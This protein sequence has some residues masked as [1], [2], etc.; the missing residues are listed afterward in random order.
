MSAKTSVDGQKSRPV[1]VR[2][3]LMDA[4]LDDGP[5][6]R[7][8]F[9]D[10]AARMDVEPHLEVRIVANMQRPHGDDVDAQTLV[11]RF[12]TRLRE[13][14]WPGKRL[15]EFLYDTRSV[16]AESH[17]R[18]VLHAKCVV[19]DRRLTFLTSA[20]FTEA[21]QQRNIEAGVVIDDARLAARVVRQFERMV[22]L[23]VLARI[24]LG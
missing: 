23:G 17:K 8:L 16:E 13:R 9:G 14:V 2:A 15:P 7:A 5:K 1:D 22:E 24:A 19:V 11:A 12:A 3:Q 18:A 21:A 20:N 10:L 4:M 6:A